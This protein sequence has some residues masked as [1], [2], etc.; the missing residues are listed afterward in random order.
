[1]GWIVHPVETPAQRKA[2]RRIQL[3]VLGMAVAW[4]SAVGLLTNRQRALL[5]PAPV[6]DVAAELARAP[7]LG[8]RPFDPSSALD[9]RDAPPTL[10]KDG[11]TTVKAW[12]SQPTLVA[13][14]VK[15]TVVV[16]HGNA[17]RALNRS[18]YAQ[19]LGPMGYRVVLAEYPGYA[20]FPGVPSETSLSGA[21]NALLDA[22]HRRFPG[23]VYLVGESLGAAAAARAVQDRGNL[24]SGVVL[25]TP[26]DSL[27]AVAK[28]R[29]RWAPVAALLQDRYDSVHALHAFTGPVTVVAAQEDRTIPPA[30][31]QALFDA[32]PT[33]RKRM[34]VVPGGHTSWTLPEDFW[35]TTLAP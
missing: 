3:T 15:G 13:S 11:A 26:W 27:L 35:A 18:V 1:M 2:V 16:F 12:V 9:G 6:V 25:I 31:A 8:V 33:A 30:H 22:V 14:P 7:R 28:E 23:P 34:L 21:N 10:L 32:L 4:A 17:D 24:V 29:Y 5:Y 19:T 20:T